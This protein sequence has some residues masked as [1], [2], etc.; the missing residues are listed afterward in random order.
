MPATNAWIE[1]GDAPAVAGAIVV[2]AL[3]RIDYL[4]CFEAMR[5]FTARRDAR[6]GDEIWLVEHDAVFPAHILDAGAIPLRRSDRGGQVTYHGPGQVVAYTLIDL[7]RRGLT[8]RALVQRLEQSVIDVLSAHGV[9]AARRAGAPGV[10]VED[11]KI[12]ALGVRIARGC[13][14]HGLALNV[15]MDLTPFARINPCG[16]AGLRVTQTR[17]VGIAANPAQIARELA[18]ALVECVTSS[19]HARFPRPNP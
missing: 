8:V 6:T 17:D 3:G 13:S 7:K 15:D 11:A 16:Y 10:Y 12:A 18:D 14:Y 2:R 19:A 5:A 1:R 4:E 9:R